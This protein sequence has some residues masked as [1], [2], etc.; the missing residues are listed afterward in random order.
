METLWGI[1]L[2]GTKIEGIIL[3]K[4]S[5]ETVARLRVPTEGNKGYEHVLQQIKKLVDMLSAESGLSPTYI[6]MGTPGTMDPILNVMKNCNS[7][8]LNGKNLAADLEHLLG[9]PFKLSNDANCFA[10]AETQMGIVA[11][12]LPTANVVFGVIMG[13][14]V[15][16]GLVVDGK[17]I[18]GRQGISGE[19]GHNF[20]D[21]TGGKCYCGQVGCVE[22]V[23]A[24]PALERYYESISGT[25]KK[26]KEITEAYRQGTDAHATATMQRLFTKFGEAI[27]V[28][29]NIIDPDAIVIGGG[30]GNIDEIYTLGVEEV[31]KHVFNHRLDTMFFK[32]K[33]GDSAGVFGAAFL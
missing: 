8:A 17:A 27:S 18:G 10:V 31:K 23:I 2:G 4:E 22:T 11:D 5:H 19:W 7:T 16:G 29:I 20:L 12:K 30:V 33:L 15:G 14:G 3:G 6:G 13:T 21:S 28:V 26:L 24:G 1:D 32:P 9:V 25:S